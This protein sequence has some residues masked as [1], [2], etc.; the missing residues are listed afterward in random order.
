MQ[1]FIPWFRGLVPPAAPRVATCQ[2]CFRADD[3]EQV[4]RTPWHNT[5]FEMLGNF[6][7]G[8]YFKRGAIEYGWEYVTK[9]LALPKERIWITVYPEDDESPSIWREAIGV[10]AG[11]IVEDKTNW[12]A[13]ADTGPC[14]PDTEIYV[15]T[16]EERG[17]GRP[18]CDPTCECPRFNE[19]WNLVFQI[20]NKTEE[21]ELEPLPKASVDTGMGFERLAAVMQGV[22]SI[23]ETD[24]LAPIVSAVVARA[25]QADPNLP[26]V[27]K[28]R[29][30]LAA[31]V[32]AEHVR[33]L[34][35]L[36]ADGFTPSN[37]GAG[38]VLRRVLRRAYR[39]GRRLGIE[40]PFLHEVAPAVV[41]TMGEVYQELRE[42]QQRITTWLDQEEKQFEETLERSLGPLMTARGCLQAPRHLRPAEGPGRRHRLRKRPCH[43]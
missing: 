27:L 23:F 8:D 9:V 14:G 16:G 7:F 30:E 40:E 36:L 22:P 4:G 15:D 26:D 37:E 42:A 12:W 19:I 32:I 13:L 28:E 24:L 33:G 34:A 1:Q 29:Q 5:F 43:G 18:E 2:K 38:Y 25:R 11:R 35:F 6:S 21:G 10:P 41:D 3:V 20:Y 39:F 17:C 31:R